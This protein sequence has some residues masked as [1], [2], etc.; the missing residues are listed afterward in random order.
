VVAINALRNPSKGT[1]SPV[2]LAM[3]WGFATG[4][5]VVGTG[6]EALLGQ[7]DRAFQ[8][9]TALRSGFGGAHLALLFAVDGVAGVGTEGG[10]WQGAVGQEQGTG[11]QGCCLNC[12][13]EFEMQVGLK[14][15]R[16]RQC[17]WTGRQGL[18][19]GPV[20][21]DVSAINQSQTGLK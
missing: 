20:N 5:D 12:H 10:R 1:G 2:G 16:R 7:L 15:A 17:H 3:D 4:H 19:H 21:N 9:R 11:Q 14:S 8:R 18:L 6:A 13:G